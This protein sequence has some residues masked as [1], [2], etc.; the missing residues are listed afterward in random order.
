MCVCIYSHIF[1]F[2]FF[3]D[4]KKKVMAERQERESE[5]ERKSIAKRIAGGQRPESM[6]YDFIHSSFLFLIRGL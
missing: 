4:I 2:W 3:L 1:S 6:M 5:R